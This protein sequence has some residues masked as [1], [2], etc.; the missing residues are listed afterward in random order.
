MGILISIV[1]ITLAVIAL[2]RL[3]NGD[4]RFR[5]LEKRLSIL[6]G[7]TST[8]QAAVQT[9]TQTTEDSS[10]TESFVQGVVDNQP[11]SLT[12]SPTQ[13]SAFDHFIEWLKRDWLIKLGGALVIIGVLILLSTVFT[14]I[15]PVGKIVTGYV[16]GA[17]LMVFGFKWAERY[18]HGGTSIH[19]TGAIIAVFTT[20]TARTPGFDLFS[21]LIGLGTIFIIAILVALTA[22]VYNKPSVAHVG[23]FMSCLAPVLI[24]SEDANFNGLVLYLLAISVGVT[25]LALVSKWRSLIFVSQIFCY[26]YIALFLLGQFNRVTFDALGHGLMLLSGLYFYTIATL[27]LARTGSEARPV[28]VVIAVVS[29]LFALLCITSQVPRELQSIA[30]ALVALVFTAGTFAIFSLTKNVSAFSVYSFLSLGL[31][32]VATWVELGERYGTLALVVEGLLA[33]VLVRR[34]SDSDKSSTPLMVLNMWPASL[35]LLEL[36]NVVGSERV[37]WRGTAEVVRQDSLIITTVAVALYFIA[38][39][40]LYR[41]SQALG[42]IVGT[43]VMVFAVIY[44]WQVTNYFLE[45]GLATLISLVIYSVAGLGVLWKGSEQN[46]EALIRIGRFALG[47]VALRVIFVDAWKFDSTFIGVAICVGTGVLL[48]S[49][50]LITKK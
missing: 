31:L 26:W 15:G 39:V 35:V 49:S 44:V 17:S 10:R 34:L 2:T 3:N 37:G 42:K 16:I 47:L 20:F 46:S 11:H 24:R 30:I 18:V 28:D 25:W 7:G 12:Q 29:A 14:M 4:A 13:P 23:L 48:L 38:A 5:D 1:A 22:L 45:P 36:F 43:V 33:L 50:T 9:I 32:M 41:V 21:P 40:M 8:L 6:E 27:S 19:V